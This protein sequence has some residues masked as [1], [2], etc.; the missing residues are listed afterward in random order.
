MKPDTPR[1]RRT[2]VRALVKQ[3]LDL[4]TEPE[5]RLAGTALDEAAERRAADL[6]ATA[7]AL[8]QGTWGAL[9]DEIAREAGE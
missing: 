8:L 7:A 2:R 3:A 4:L 9:A 1:Q 6:L 5:H